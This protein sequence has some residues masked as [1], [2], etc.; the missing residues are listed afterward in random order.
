MA[1]LLVID[2]EV[3]IRE[4]LKKLLLLDKYEVYSAENGIEGLKMVETH[5]PDIIIADIKMP[6]ISGI[7]VLK[8]VKTRNNLIEVI[9]ITGHG[10]CETAI[11]AMKQGAFGYIQKPIEYDELHIEI[12]KALEKQQ[13]K[14]KIDSYVKELEYRVNEWEITFNS[15]SDM[16]SI[17][18]K[19]YKIVK[20]NKA[21]IETFK[22]N[23]DTS[24]NKLCYEIFSCLN[25]RDCCNAKTC[26]ISKS[27][28]TTEMYY[29]ELDLYFDVIASPIF[30]GDGEFNGTIHR[31]KDITQRKLHEEKIKAS[32]QEKTLLLREIHHR[33]K[34]NME[35]ISSLIELQIE[36]SSDKQL[37]GMYNEM[38]NRIRSMSLIHK[39][40]YQSE[41]LSEVNFN[42]YTKNLT[43]D[44]INSYCIDPSMITVNIN[45]DDVLINMDT[46]MPCCLII[47]ELVT[48]SLKYAFTETKTGTLEISM[49]NVGDNMYELI[50]RDDGKGI[51]E[52]FD[53][54]KTSS[55]GLKL[56]R[57][58][59]EYQ[60]GGKIEMNTSGGTEFKLRFKELQYKKRV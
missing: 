34:N 2:D 13:M 19:D 8:E 10:G 57:T 26:S 14:M 55:L 6:K 41:N 51:P 11:E 44:L 50:V 16:L 1:K 37:I 33:V 24:N 27:S 47:N 23:P 48:N 54:N 60:L 35:I 3:I 7:D 36:D 46:A 49:Q 30:G 31:F 12:E 25:E 28:C 21:F 53:I 45:I 29:P 43:A 56:I 42:D 9:M 58:L 20:C 5:L 4:R 15:V 17:H 52:G 18:D 59:A 39:M 22:F 40:L 38:K 32:L